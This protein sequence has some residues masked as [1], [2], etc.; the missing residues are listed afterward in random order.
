MFLKLPICFLG[1]YH[2]TQQAS[3]GANGNAALVLLRLL[4][5]GHGIGSLLTSVTRPL[6]EWKRWPVVA[7]WLI[8]KLQRNND[9]CLWQHFDDESTPAVQGAYSTL[10]KTATLGLM[11]P[12]TVPSEYACAVCLNYFTFIM[13]L[14]IPQLSLHA[15]GRLGLR[16]VQRWLLQ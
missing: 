12:P 7:A 5:C 10:S 8:F 6:L 1:G 11:G 9:F 16:N 4:L 3:S 2:G 14:A 15:Q 13:A